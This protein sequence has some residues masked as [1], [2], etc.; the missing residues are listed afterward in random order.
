MSNLQELAKSPDGDAWFLGTDERTG[1][2]FVIHRG[3][4]TSGSTER[5]LSLEDFLDRVTYRP[6]QEALIAILAVRR[7]IAPA[8]PRE[9]DK[10]RSLRLAEEYLRLGGRRRAKVDDNIV[11]TRLWEDEPAIA[12]EFWNVHIASLDDKLRR[13]VELLLPSTSE[14]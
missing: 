6:A 7:D 4:I 14:N 8:G 11:N 3:N 9:N 1:H 5:R 10:T 13:E 12:S 2:P